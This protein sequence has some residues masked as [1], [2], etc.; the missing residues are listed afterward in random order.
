MRNAGRWKPAKRR[1]AVQR[2]QIES[3]NTRQSSGKPSTSCELRLGAQIEN[4]FLQRAARKI[5]HERRGKKRRE[6]QAK[7]DRAQ[8][9]ANLV[10]DCA[11]Q[12]KKSKHAAT[13]AA[14]NCIFD[15]H[16]LSSLNVQQ[17]DLQLAWHRRMDKDVP[18]CK[19]LLRRLEKLKALT[20]AVERHNL[21]EAVLTAICGT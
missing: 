17:I 5:Q 11:R 18:K 7:A 4:T 8:V 14:L 10:S 13:L 3:I 2:A 1:S 21:Q 19:L 12:E 15:V 9:T 20:E 6:K 16:A